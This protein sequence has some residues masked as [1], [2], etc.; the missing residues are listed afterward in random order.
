MSYTITVPV[1]TEPMAREISGVSRSVAGT[2]TAVVA[3]QTAVTEAQKQSSK[4]ICQNVNKGF[5]TLIRSQISQKIAINQSEVDSLL[6]SMATQKKQL[7]SIKEK[8]EHD[9]KMIS[10]RYTKLFNSLNQS[11]KNS[12]SEIDKQVID[13]SVK[14]IGKISKRPLNLIATGPFM[15]L[16]A[17]TQSQKIVSANVKKRSA[18]MLE[19]VKTFLLSSKRQKEI[20]ESVLDSKPIETTVLDISVTTIVCESVIDASE[21]KNITISLPQEISGYSKSGIKNSVLSGM[22]QIK[23]EEGQISDNV[24]SE[25][26][27]LNA[28]SP[29]CEKMKKITM[30]LFDKSNFQISTGM[31]V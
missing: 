25:F 23:W 21:N 9:Y 12:I 22:S 7:L 15:Q 18:R 29:N 31:A 17:L 1:S 14:E 20:I 4:M 26:L 28:E 3:M 13:F 6:M 24:K 19:F 8:M 10:S 30:E 27:K 16:E 5:H 11:L 2:T